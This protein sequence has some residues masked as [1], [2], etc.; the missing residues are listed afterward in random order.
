MC[1]YQDA[2]RLKS[3]I[4]KVHKLKKETYELQ[5]QASIDRYAS[6]TL[7]CPSASSLA[8]VPYPHPHAVYSEELFLGQAS[9]LK[10]IELI[11]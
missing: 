10:H 5:N 8:L 9:V 1:F 4:E 7:L 2:E 11:Y 6:V 3:V